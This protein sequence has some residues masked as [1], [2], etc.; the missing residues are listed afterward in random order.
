M[1]PAFRRAAPLLALASLPLAVLALAASAALG[2]V[3]Y[4]HEGP[5]EFESQLKAGQIHEATINKRLRRSWRYWPPA[6]TARW[7][8]WPFRRVV[9]AAWRRCSWAG[10][11]PAKRASNCSGE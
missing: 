4:Q 3:G 2:A 10:A 1:K 7:R 11:N 9:A 5:A 8:G 6:P